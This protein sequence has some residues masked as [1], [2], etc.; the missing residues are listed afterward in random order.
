[1][2]R[3]SSRRPDRISAPGPSAPRSISPSEP[4]VTSTSPTRG[5]TASS[6]LPT[7]DL[8]VPRRPS[9]FRPLFRSPRRFIAILAGLLVAGSLTPGVAGGASAA[10]TWQLPGFVRSIG[11]RGEAGVYP[12]GMEYNPVTDEILVGDYW[13]FKIRRYDRV[14]GRQIGAFFR[15]PN[16]R[17]GQP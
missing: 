8:P 10:G 5:T 11:G 7:P 3:C 1:M 6:N 16:L 14:S 9:M 2:R 15:A 13:N 4:M 17:K 12:W